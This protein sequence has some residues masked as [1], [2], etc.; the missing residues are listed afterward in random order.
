MLPKVLL[1]H[2]CLFSLDKEGQLSFEQKPEKNHVI[3]FNMQDSTNKVRRVVLY[4]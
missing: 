1:T 3:V 2:R 4:L